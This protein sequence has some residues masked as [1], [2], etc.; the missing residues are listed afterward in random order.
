MSNSYF[1][2]NLVIQ[3]FSVPVLGLTHIPSLDNASAETF[4]SFTCSVAFGMFPVLLTLTG[5][6]TGFPQLGLS[7][8]GEPFI[9][10]CY[11]FFSIIHIAL[12]GGLG[13]GAR[14]YFA[15]L[16]AVNWH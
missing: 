5:A 11:K 12:E 6:G 4:G 8:G 13:L 3:R 2:V 10:I 7:L 9:H 14:W 1:G 15:C 16:V